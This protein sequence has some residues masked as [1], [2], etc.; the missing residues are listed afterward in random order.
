M[1]IP[2]FAEPSYCFLFLVNFFLWDFFICK[3]T[4]SAQK[5][6]RVLLLP[7]SASIL[8]FFGKQVIIG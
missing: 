6:C 7:V 4:L 5:A 8:T 3:Q 2:E 1:Q